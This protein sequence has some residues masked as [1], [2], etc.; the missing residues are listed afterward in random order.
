MRSRMP[1]VAALI[2][3]AI[4]QLVIYLTSVLNIGCTPSSSSIPVQSVLD[5][6]TLA[7]HNGRVLDLSRIQVASGNATPRFINFPRTDL[8]NT[9]PAFMQLQDASKDAEMERCI[10]RRGAE[11][12]RWL[13]ARL[14]DRQA[15]RTEGVG[16]SRIP[17]ECALPDGT[18]GA[19]VFGPLDRRV[20]DAAAVGGKH[21]ARFSL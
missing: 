16:K 21:S 10:G 3:I 18:Y 14:G 7:Y 11:A 4:I 17:V 13:E 2:A 8:T 12:A 9:F 1:L 15:F 6:D 5:S 19:C 20:V